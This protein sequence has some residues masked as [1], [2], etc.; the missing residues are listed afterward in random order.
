MEVLVKICDWI[1]IA[2]ILASIVYLFASKSLTY[3]NTLTIF[4]VYI[5]IVEYYGGYLSD[6]GKKNVWLYNYSSIVEMGYCSW[7]IAKMYSVKANARAANIF[8]VVIFIISFINIVFFQGKTQF[9]S[10]TY[11]LYSLLL[12]WLCVYYFY[13][14]LMFPAM[15]LLTRK[16]EFWICTAIL[17]SFSCGFPIFCL[18][19][20]YN[21]KISVQIWPLISTVNMVT[22]IMYYSLFIV[23]FLCNI[24]IKKYL[25]S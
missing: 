2:C 23:G 10:I 14:L 19:N 9:H 21:H 24:K 7:L 8:N 5:F 1:L 3:L 6:H 16:T 15:E 12:I 22:G 4:L 20:F 11:G 18:N 25:P 13:Q 17:F